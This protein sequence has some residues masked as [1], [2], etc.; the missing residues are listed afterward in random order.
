MSE[1]KNINSGKSGKL[2]KIS[3]TFRQKRINDEG[4]F[5]D[6]D[7]TLFFLNVNLKIQF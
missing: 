7:Q 1:K 4:E 5:I 3:L 2:H 6:I